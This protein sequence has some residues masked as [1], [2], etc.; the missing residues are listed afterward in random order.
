M[1]QFR[2]LAVID[3]VDAGLLAFAQP[4]ERTRCSAVVAYR[5]DDAAWGQFAGDRSDPDRVIGAGGSQSAHGHA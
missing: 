3:D 1:H 5:A 2:H 4:Q